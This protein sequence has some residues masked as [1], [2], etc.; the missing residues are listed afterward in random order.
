MTVDK[1][2]AN[3]SID[4]SQRIAVSA[5]P[6]Q[7]RVIEREGPEMLISNAPLLPA[8]V[9]KGRFSISVCGSSLAPFRPS[10]AA[11]P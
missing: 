8:P 6:L 4:P 10:I 7:F 9:D 5:P 2:V 11:A 3:E 1:D